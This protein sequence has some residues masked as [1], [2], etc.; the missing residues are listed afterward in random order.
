MDRFADRMSG[1]LAS[2]GVD[3][4]PYDSFATWHVDVPHR[5]WREAVAA[6]RDAAGCT[7]LDWLSVVDE[8][9]G[10]LRV[11][12]HLLALPPEPPGVDAVLVRALLPAGRRGIDSLVPV[13]AGAAWHEREAAEMFGLD[14]VGGVDSAPLLLAEHFEGHPLRKDFVLAS[15]AVTPWPGAKDPESASGAPSRRRSRPPGVP[16]PGAWGATAPAAR[17]RR[18]RRASDTVTPPGD[19]RD[20]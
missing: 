7:Y 18:T 16:A 17:T 9:P 8:A 12:V 1:A 3:A 5:R 11:V 19:G 4:V 20:G 2:I 15:R 13:F 6:L 10:G 14:F